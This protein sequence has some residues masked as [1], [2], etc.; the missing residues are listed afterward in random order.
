MINKGWNWNL[1]NEDVWLRPSEES[2]IMLYRWS[3]LNFHKVLD[4]GCGR[5]RHT[6]LFAENGFETTGMDVSESAVE[7]TQKL[8][9]DHGQKCVIKQA[10]MRQIPFEDESFDA[11]FSYLTLHHSD[12][13]GVASALNEIYR[14]LKPNGEVYFSLNSCASSSYKNN[15]FPSLDEFTRIKTVAGPEEG[16]PHFYANEE[17]LYSLLKPFQIIWVNHTNTLYHNGKKSG[18]WDYYVLAKKQ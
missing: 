3:G 6:L 5:G 11:V 18:S 12:T 2:I 17:I 10:D 1:A 8:L 13:K 14:I 9:A 7:S 4:L 16:E 15:D